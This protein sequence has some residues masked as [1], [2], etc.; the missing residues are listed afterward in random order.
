[1]N[2]RVLAFDFDGTIAEEGLVPNEIIEVFRQAYSQ[3]H[4]LFLVTG[5]LYRQANIER[6]LPYL[7][8]I[9]WENGAVLEHLPSK[10]VSLPFGT[11]PKLMVKDLEQTGIEMLTGMAIA[12]TW[13]Q[14]ESLVKRISDQHNYLPSLDWNKMAL[15]ILPTGANKGSGLTR[16]LDQCQFST[17][18]L[19]AFGDGE[20]DHSLLAMAE[21]AV[22]V[23]DAVP[24]LQKIAHVVAK[25]PGPSGVVEILQRLLGREGGE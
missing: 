7:T 22:A 9:V 14:H 15:M 10:R 25:N 5:R 11:L 13:A 6:I 20:N 19:M 23:Q 12:A 24:S 3:T 2:Q 17:K 21:T 1:M 4:A 8:G 18:P 16:L